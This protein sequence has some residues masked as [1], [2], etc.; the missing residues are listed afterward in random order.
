M[1]PSQ[2]RT[3]V[4]ALYKQLLYL[5]REWPQG[6][7]LFRDRAQSVFRRNAS[8]ADERRAADMLRHGR[9]VIKEIEALYKLKKYRAMKKRYYS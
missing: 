5:G 6:Y 8:V 3:A 7:Q 4:L 2:H 9:F 1:F